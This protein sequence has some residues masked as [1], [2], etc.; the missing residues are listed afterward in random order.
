MGLKFDMVNPAAVNAARDHAAELVTRVSEETRKSIRSIMTRSFTQGIP[1]REAAKLIQPLIGLT[2]RQANAVLRHYADLVRQGLSRATAQRMARLYAQKLRRGR[3]LTI[4][5]TETISA[6]SR[7]Q[8][9]AWR[10]AQTQGRLGSNA[11]KTWI[12][13]PDDRLCRYCRAMGGKTVPL[14][15][16]FVSQFGAV[17]APPLH[18]NCRCAIGL[19]FGSV[20]RAA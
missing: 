1:T 11:L 3:A 12:V 6:A 14:D 5:R 13:T 4:A 19:A 20:Q 2:S 9:T 7:G 8:L 10:V 17:I 15:A 18:P 16:N